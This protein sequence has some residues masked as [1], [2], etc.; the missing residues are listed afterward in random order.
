M[1]LLLDEHYP[2]RIAVELRR[3]GHDVVAAPERSDLRGLGDV[4][5]FALMASEGRAILTEDAADFLP[6]VRA[7]T[8]RGTDHFGV[9][10]T[11]PRQFPRTSR[12]IGRLVAALDA[13]LVARPD[14]DALRRQT[15]WLE[16]LR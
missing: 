13:F 7:A 15:W 14:E 12:A 5:L 4:A 3:R 10:L 1:R 6:I 9:V 16:P 11:S 8:V 2:P